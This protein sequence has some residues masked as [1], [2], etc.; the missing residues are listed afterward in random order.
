MSKRSLK[1]GGLAKRHRR[2]V[3]MALA[4]CGGYGIQ[5]DMIDE[6]A[7]EILW[8]M[9]TAPAGR[10]QA[11]AH[12]VAR[13]RLARQL[14]IK[15]RDVPVRYIYARAVAQYEALRAAYGLGPRRDRGARELAFDYHSR[16]FAI[17]NGV[18]PRCGAAGRFGPGGGVCNCGF[19]L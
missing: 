1:D 6:V 3:R 17:E 10:R 11:A 13:R 15:E 12:R 2:A 16:Q 5:P 7:G 9:R 14:G 18:C 8:A 19:C 4:I